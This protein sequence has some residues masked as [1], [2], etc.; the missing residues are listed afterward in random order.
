MVGGVQVYVVHVHD[1]HVGE[2]IEEVRKI[3]RVE[4]CEFVR[5]IS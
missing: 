5:K 4:V 3:A 1:D 2:V